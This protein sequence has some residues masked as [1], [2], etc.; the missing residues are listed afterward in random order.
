MTKIIIEIASEQDAL[1]LT[2]F[3]KRLNGVVQWSSDPLSDSS[4]AFAWLEEL[5]NTHPF[6]EIVD[7]VTW[8]TEQRQ[9]RFLMR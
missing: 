2:E 4:S 9:D 6:D 1:L 5:A 8:Q 7:V 3:A